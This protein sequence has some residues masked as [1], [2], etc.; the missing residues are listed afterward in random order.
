MRI[1]FIISTIIWLV[2]NTTVYAA[3]KTFPSVE[4][5]NAYRGIGR[6]VP[7]PIL[8]T[9]TKV[10]LGSSPLIKK[11]ELED[12]P[13]SPASD[14]GSYDLFGDS[15]EEII[16]GRCSVPPVTPSPAPPSVV[17]DDKCSVPA[18][19]PSPALW[20]PASSRT[21]LLYSPVVSGLPSVVSTS[22]SL[23]CSDSMGIS[24]YPYSE[25]VGHVTFYDISE[26]SV[27]GDPDMDET[28]S[29]NSAST[30]P[31][32]F[33]Y[34]IPD[35]LTSDVDEK[36]TPTAVNQQITDSYH[37][38]S[39]GLIAASKMSYIPNLEIIHRLD[40]M[41]IEPILHTQFAH[42]GIAAG[43]GWKYRVNNV[44][45]TGVHNTSRQHSYR[46]S[47]SYHAK[48]HGGIIGGD[49]NINDA[50]LLGSA[51]SHITSGFSYASGKDTLSSRHNLFSLYGQYELTNNISLQ[52]IGSYCEGKVRTFITAINGEGSFKNQGYSFENYAFYKISLPRVTIIPQLGFKYN[53]YRDAGYT[54]INNANSIGVASH[55]ASMYAAMAGIK[56]MASPINLRGNIYMIPIFTLGIEREIKSHFEPISVLVIYKNNTFSNT[57]NN[58]KLPVTSYNM[59]L[60]LIMKYKGYELTPSYHYQF[61]EKYQ[62]HQIAVKLK[63]LF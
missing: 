45:V 17:I 21:P 28:D 56:F 13:L 25:I 36:D 44:W 16:D 22:T 39:I 9:L 32:H 12:R 52:A 58:V 54:I 5:K 19:S 24:A 27:T 37:D 63:F 47:A 34:Y 31:Y 15:S 2:T 23:S 53:R 20:S 29:Y 10:S 11:I 6:P 38:T 8:K 59:G 55:T 14:T 33:I 41:N 50:L 51:Y 46:K 7:V 18:F 40:S 26:K 60:N 61:R 35:T 43:D 30:S 3:S 48:A 57:T 42:S 4:T 62:N 49:I 1:F